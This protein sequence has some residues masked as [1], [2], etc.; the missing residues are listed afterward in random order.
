MDGEGKV[1][2]RFGLECPND[3]VAIRDA[4]AFADGEAFEIW[5]ETRIVFRR[6]SDPPE[7]EIIPIPRP[8]T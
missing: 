8:A 2:A 7:P 3:E 4:A 5:Q 6:T 1:R